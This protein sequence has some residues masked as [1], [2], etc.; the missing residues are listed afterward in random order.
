MQSDLLAV[1]A[2]VPMYG[3]P[4]AYERHAL[5]GSAYYSVHSINTLEMECLITSLSRLRKHHPGVVAQWLERRAC[6]SSAPQVPGSKGTWCTAQH[7]PLLSGHTTLTQL[8]CCDCMLHNQSMRT[9]CACSAWCAEC[10]RVMAAAGHQ[11]HPGD[12]S[13]DEGND[14]GSDVQDGPRDVG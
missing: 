10:P 8:L 7:S 1:Q 14:D 13:V 6:E 4:Y 12:R 11:L 3:L 5:C 9:T 2:L